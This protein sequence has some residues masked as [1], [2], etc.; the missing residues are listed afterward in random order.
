MGAQEK[1]GGSGAGRTKAA[2]LEKEPMMTETELSSGSQS[3]AGAR[4]HSLL[5]LVKLYMQYYPRI[6]SCLAAIVVAVTV[7][8]MAL[9]FRSKPSYTRNQ[10]MHDYSQLDLHH[11][12]QA[13]R[14]DHWCLWG[15]DNVCKCDDFTTPLSRE[16]KKGWV[17]THFRNTQRI[18]GTKEYDVVF[19]GDEV[20]EGWNG[21]W[22]GKTGIP[23]AD[24]FQTKDYFTKAFTREGGG[25]FEGL[26]LGVMGDV[27]SLLF[28]Y[29][30]VWPTSKN[31]QQ[32]KTATSLS[33]I[34][35]LLF[36]HFCWYV[37]CDSH[38]MCCGDSGT[39]NCPALCNPKFSG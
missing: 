13:S 38:P 31:H 34:Y 35:S 17:Q 24:A 16:E 10:L 33:D 29:L 25:E 39:V 37:P 1:H 32:T 18:D 26:A 27:V 36:H 23:S 30:L 14:V 19:I 15:G 12:D 6:T 5:V 7:L 9:S 22:L 20:V 28:G 11:V 2:A 8:S 3:A 4:L 21:E